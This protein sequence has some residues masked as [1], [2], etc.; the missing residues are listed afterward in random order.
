MDQK[1][2]I[3]EN[4]Q[5]KSLKGGSSESNNDFKEKLLK[6]KRNKKSTSSRKMEPKVVGG[7]I[8]ENKTDGSTLESLNV[9]HEEHQNTVSEINFSV[10]CRSLRERFSALG[11]SV[12]PKI[13]RS[14]VDPVPSTSKK[15]DNLGGSDGSINV[16]SIKNRNSDE[17]ERSPGKSLELSNFYPKL[18]SF[19]IA[20]R[21]LHQC[22]SRVIRTNLE[23]MHHNFPSNSES[24]N[25]SVSLHNV[26]HANAIEEVDLPLSSAFVAE[27]SKRLEPSTKN[28][29]NGNIV[30]GEKSIRNKL[31]RFAHPDFCEN[32]SDLWNQNK[33]EKITYSNVMIGAPKIDVV[34]AGEVNAVLPTIITSTENGNV[35]PLPANANDKSASNEIN[36]ASAD[37]AENLENNRRTQY[38]FKS[39][40]SLST[41]QDDLEELN[42]ILDD[43]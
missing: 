24:S 16:S 15:S 37:F 21:K 42:N 25:F 17:K 41:C 5:N 34:N 27:K 7:S 4:F 30:S 43:L 14:Y 1:K 39:T 8:F 13:E 31:M 26:T 22:K 33:N 11:K 6:M 2:K 19:V 12:K 32:A 18:P 23:S 36:D 40:F 35:G 29:V 3:V 38:G 20:K 9:V 28:A 10:H